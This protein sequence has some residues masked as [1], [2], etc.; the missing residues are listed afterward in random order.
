MFEV[1]IQR[2]FSAAHYLRGYEGNCSKLHGHNWVVDAVVEA[3][4]LDELGIAIDFRVLKREIDAVVEKLDHSC[5]NDLEAFLDVN[6]TSE[7]IAEYVF[8][9]LS[10]RLNSDRVRVASVRICESPG[11]GATYRP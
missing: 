1:D 6:P 9:V 3:S 10:D 11:A 4:E 2:D 8:N 7:R 5:L